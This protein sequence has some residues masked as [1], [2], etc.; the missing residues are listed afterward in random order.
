MS[1]SAAKR[2]KATFTGDIERSSLLAEVVERNDTPDAWG[3]E[4]INEADDGEVFMAVFY[5]P[6][7][8][9]LALEYA[10]AKYADVRMK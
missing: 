5:G 1:P 8:Q 7:A 2:S 3:V 9:S 10:G 4:A 6:D